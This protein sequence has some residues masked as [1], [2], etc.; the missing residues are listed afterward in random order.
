VVLAFLRAKVVHGEPLWLKITAYVVLCVVVTVG[1]FFIQNVVKKKLAE[2]KQQRG[3]VDIG[4]DE[5]GIDGISNTP[6]YGKLI[7]EVRCPNVGPV[8]VTIDSC[9]GHLDVAEGPAL[10]FMKN[11]A[12]Q[13]KYF[14]SYL[15]QRKHQ[16]GFPRS[17]M[18][19]ASTT[20]S[21][22][23]PLATAELVQAINSDEKVVLVVGRTVYKDG[24][25][26]RTTDLCEMMVPPFQR[27]PFWHRCLVHEG[28][29]SGGN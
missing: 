29:Q 8:I 16:E 23:G 21:Y 9:D 28:D 15:R 12:L 1:L 11:Q 24:T 18:L 14:Q 17:E 27:N 4:P 6:D 7:V 5:I 3:F 2:S 19:R 25:G 26:T 10:A 13:E 20:M 22:F